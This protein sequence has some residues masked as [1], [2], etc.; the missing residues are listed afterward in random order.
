MSKVYS[1]VYLRELWNLW[2]LTQPDQSYKVVY[3]N[4]DEMCRHV[5]Y[6][7]QH[8][9][10]L[11]EKM[12]IF[13]PREPMQLLKSL[14]TNSLEIYQK[15]ISKMVNEDDVKL[16]AERANKTSFVTAAVELLFTKRYGDVRDRNDY[17]YKMRDDIMILGG[18]ALTN[19]MEFTDLR[20]REC[21]AFMT[22]SL[23]DEGIDASKYFAD[24]ERGEEG[25]IVALASAV[26]RKVQTPPASPSNGDFVDYISKLALELFKDPEWAKKLVT[27]WV[28]KIREEGR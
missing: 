8:W 2:V 14:T 16:M 27:E 10:A 1:D 18:R 6:G 28:D 19:F 26:I 5:P 9:L 15:P 13:R 11:I 25:M 23:R 17:I 12:D 22:R 4:F 24:A 21:A 20:Y 3:A 7:P